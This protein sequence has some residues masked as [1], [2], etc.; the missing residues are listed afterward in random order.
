M[1]TKTMT[2]LYD[3]QEKA[4]ETAL[5]LKA[6]KIAESDI[7]VVAAKPPGRRT[8]SDGAT[9]NMTDTGVGQGAAVGGT[10][11]AAAGLAAGLG[12][13]MIPGIGPVMALGWLLP[14]AMG[15][16]VGASGGGVL[17]ALIGAG[18]NEEHAHVYAEGVRRGGALVTVRADDAQAPAVEAILARRSIN[19]EA[20]G[21]LYRSEGWTQFD[22]TAPPLNTQRERTVEKTTV[23][24]ATPQS[25]T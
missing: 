23:R 7:S 15:A 2:G 6:A 8:A 16:A 20:R 14:T 25:R 22:E 18:V 4:L 5:E 21:E 11:G 24:E 9:G 19:P 3:T 10:L 12:A 13:L 1:A 17:G